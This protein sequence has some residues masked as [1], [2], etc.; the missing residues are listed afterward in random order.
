MRE[1]AVADEDEDLW[2]P[3]YLSHRPDRSPAV[4]REEQLQDRISKLRDGGQRPPG[5]V[6][7]LSRD[8][9]VRTAISVAD[10]EGPDAISMRRIARELHAG[11]MSLYWHVSSKEELLDLM[12]DAVQGEMAVPVTTGE[13]RADLRA[14]ALGQRATLRR[15]RWI[16]PFMGGRPP[17][18]PKALRNAE[19]ALALF[20]PRRPDGT[21][22]MTVLTSVTTY[23]MGA[24]LREQQEDR[25]QHDEKRMQERLGLSEEELHEVYEGYI[26][27]VTQSGRYPHLTEMIKQGIDP[28]ALE[29][30]DER[31]EFGL[32]CL[33]DG[34]VARLGSRDPAT[35][36]E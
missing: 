4:R 9:I 12:L 5:R 30:Q 35:A 11:A 29:T 14:M 22:A 19:Q 6:R 32:D 3:F 36:P 24:V 34:I 33:L 1:A 7:S 28:D 18:G 23:V 17:M 20:T 10:A 13:V 26:D 21:T 16:M 15:H 8:E 31:F 25:S 27:Q 2:P